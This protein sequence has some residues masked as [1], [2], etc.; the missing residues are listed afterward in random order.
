VLAWAVRGAVDWYRSLPKG[1]PELSSMALAKSAQRN[2][3]DFV[4][5]WIEE[6]CLIEPNA[7]TTSGTLYE[8][9]ASWCKS[10]GVIAKQMTGF[11]QSLSKRGLSNSQR[12]VS[13]RTNPVR[14]FTGISLLS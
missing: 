12:R 1:L 10:N 8:S 13:D 6:C 14:G 2:E 7:F 11:S 5:Q 9:Y 4:Q 3:M